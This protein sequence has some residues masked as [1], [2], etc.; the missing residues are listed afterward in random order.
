VTGSVVHV[1]ASITC[2]H[3][4]LVNIAPGSAGVMVGGQPAASVADTFAVTG[5]AFV[6]G[7]TPHPCMT[8]CWT[9]PA[10]RVTVRGSP[11]VTQASVGLATA[12]DQAPQGLPTLGAVQ[13][14]V[15]AQ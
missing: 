11:V 9:V 10:A 13:P 6:I 5:C 2:P 1:G 12:A 8:I 14:R 7:N 15:V 3:G 4:G